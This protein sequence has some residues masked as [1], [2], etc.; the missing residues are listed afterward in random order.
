MARTVEQQQ[1]LEKMF[2]SFCKTCLRNRN[3][4]LIR[5]QRF[6][7]RREVPFCRLA[8]EPFAFDTYFADVDM[9]DVCGTSISVGDEMLADALRKLAPT[10][11]EIVLLSYFMRLS[12]RQIAELIGMARSTVQYQR[13]KALS[14]LRSMLDETE[15]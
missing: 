11:C 5:H 1:A 13:S 8:T 3:R 7:A 6:L 15:V 12:D 2:D 10:F 4:D 14:Q 9:F